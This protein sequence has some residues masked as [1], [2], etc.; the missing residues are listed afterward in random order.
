MFKLFQLGASYFSENYMRA[1]K[2]GAY[3][4]E[5]EILEAA[6]DRDQPVEVMV[7]KLLK[8]INLGAL[9][10]AEHMLLFGIDLIEQMKGK[11]SKK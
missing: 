3:V 8:A 9:H 2:K 5:K 6:E 7:R 4:A 10:A 11:S 1:V